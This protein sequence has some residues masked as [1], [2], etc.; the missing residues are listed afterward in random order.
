MRHAA[1]TESPFTLST[2]WEETLL[3]RSMAYSTIE[4]HDLV[5]QLD[6]S[7]AVIGSLHTKCIRL[8]QPCSA[9]LHSIAISNDHVRGKRQRSLDQSAQ[10]RSA[11]GGHSRQFLEARRCSLASRDFPARSHHSDCLPWYSTRILV[12]VLLMHLCVRTNIIVIT[13][14]TFEMSRNACRSASAC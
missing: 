14:K 8:R 1:V 9:K 12:L 11:P 2:A 4:A 5:C 3:H 13:G 10:S 7:G 6:C